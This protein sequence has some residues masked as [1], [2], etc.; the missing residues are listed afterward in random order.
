MGETT[1]LVIIGLKRVEQTCN[2]F[3]HSLAVSRRALARNVPLEPIVLKCLFPDNRECG[4]IRVIGVMEEHPNGS[5]QGCYFCLQIDDAV[6]HL[7]VHL[8]TLQ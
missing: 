1:S 6:C 2:R 7:V 8:C 4:V 5:A 3:A